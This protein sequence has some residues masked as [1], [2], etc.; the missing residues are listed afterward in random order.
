M[1]AVFV[2]RDIL[3]GQFIS[4]GFFMPTAELLSL[5]EKQDAMEQKPT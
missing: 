1:P 4:L 2:V 5:A 3:L